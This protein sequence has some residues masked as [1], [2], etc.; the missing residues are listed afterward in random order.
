MSFW[1]DPKDEGAFTGF[2]IDD[3]CS[4]NRVY[5]N[6]FDEKAEIRSY[7]K[8]EREEYNRLRGRDEQGKLK[9][10]EWQPGDWGYEW[11]ANGMLKTVT[12]PEGKKIRFEYDAL[13]RRTAKIAG[14]K[15]YRYIWDGNV[16]LHEWNYPL[17][18]RP[19]LV[20]NSEGEIYY[21][22]PEPI[23][24][25][26]SWIYENGALVPTGRIEQGKTHS[27]ISDYIGRP[28]QVYNEEGECVW[29]TEYD[30][31][32][33]LRNL[34]GNRE[35]IP[36]RQLG[37]YE[38]VETGLFYNRFRYYNPETGMYISQDPIG[39]EGNNPNLYAYTHDS[40]TMVDPLGLQ[41]I[42]EGLPRR[43]PTAGDVDMAS[44]RAA[45]REAM[46]RL[47]IPTSQTYKSRIIKDPTDARFRIE[48]IYDL[49]GKKLGELNIHQDGHIFTNKN[50]VPINYEK[51][52]YHTFENGVK[53]EG[54]ITYGKG[55]PR[56]TQTYLDYICK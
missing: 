7:S 40:N 26:V 49:N 45:R 23:E 47:G 14:D 21:N 5:D 50:G 36:F 37:Q 1:I 35:L 28:I 46:R 3:K 9:Q 27:I 13:G 20:A 10:P 52:H 30:I 33:N 48:E 16:L 44:V 18:R 6:I 55:K 43:A 12:T 38:D 25:L 51:P 19:Q 15:I 2:W 53:Q 29:E 31:Y 32:G 24:N 56:G 8:K 39:I 22:Q 34:K 54:H 11:L 4:K 41:Q 17:G 42:P